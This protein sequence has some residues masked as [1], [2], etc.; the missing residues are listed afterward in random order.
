MATTFL[1]R[2]PD[3]GSVEVGPDVVRLLVCMTDPEQS[4]YAFIC[5]SC[6]D[7]V[8]HSVDAKAIIDLNRGGVPSRRWTPV[9]WSARQGGPPI[10]IDDLIDFHANDLDY[11]AQ[12]LCGPS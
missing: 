5:P 10:T 4:Y 3:C 11:E 8:Y 2:C 12:R 1:V 6:S 9:V 7:E